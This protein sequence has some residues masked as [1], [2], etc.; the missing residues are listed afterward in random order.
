MKKEIINFNS[1]KTDKLFKELYGDDKAVKVQK[2][3]YKEALQAFSDIFPSYDEVS[4]YSAP[5]RTE[6]GGNHT[7]H[8]NGQVI[9]AAVDL[10][11]IAIAAFHDEQIIRIKSKGYR[12]DTIDISDLSVSED[13]KGSSAALIRGIVSRFAQLGYKIGGFDAYTTSNVL[14]GSGLSSSAA[15]EVLVG[16]ILNEH[17]NEGKISAPEIAIISQYAENEFF[18]KKSGLMDQM[19]SSVGGFAYIDFKNPEKPQVEKLDFDFNK[20]GYTLCITDTKGNHAN[21][22]DDYVAVPYEMKLVAEFLGKSVLREADENEFYK[23]IPEIREKFSDRAV[24]RSA[25]FFAET[26]RAKAEADA[27]TENNFDEFLRLVNE[28]GTSS[29]QLL[30]NAYSCNHPDEQGVPVGLMISGKV[31]KGKGAYRIHGGGFAGTI[32]AFVPNETV[33]EYVHEMENIFGYGSCYI[34]HIRPYG[35]ICILT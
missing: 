8:Q 12:M 2:E 24:L 33:D 5:G 28:S 17:F 35:G 7:D 16:T 30:Q 20:T 6:I 15:F 3:R 1:D 10:D 26:K 13:E 34:M 22:T 11:V 27:L 23:K 9:A 32:Q 18:G 19:V 21:L 25:H 14:K 4:V 31:L 29:Y